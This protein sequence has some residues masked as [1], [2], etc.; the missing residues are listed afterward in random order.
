[1]AARSEDAPIGTAFGVGVHAM[2]TGPVGPSIVYNTDRFHLEGIVAMTNVDGE[3]G[4]DITLAGRG[5]FHIHQ[6]KASSL[7]IG[8]GVGFAR[9]ETEV[10]DPRGGTTTETTT[11]IHLEGGAQIRFFATPNVALSASLGLGIVSGDADVL[12]ITGQ[13]TG[14]VGLT[15]FLF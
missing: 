1:M 6:A 9:N 8:G 12:V 14:A 2:L 4:T 5:W 13:L 11:D 3:E 7:S 15:Y 10:P